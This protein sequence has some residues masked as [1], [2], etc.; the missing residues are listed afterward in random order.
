[1]K[2]AFGLKALRKARGLSRKMRMNHFFAWPA[3]PISSATVLP[4]SHV[5]LST[6]PMHVVDIVD[7]VDDVD[8]CRG[9]V[10]AERGR[11][12]LVDYR[13]TRSRLPH[14][15]LRYSATRVRWQRLGAV[16]ADGE[17]AAK[18]TARSPNRRKRTISPRI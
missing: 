17:N 9:A 2:A 14:L 18:L 13:W 8:G 3:P 1:M 4:V 7:R 10:G 6:L 12:L 11:R 15:A 16:Y 5:V